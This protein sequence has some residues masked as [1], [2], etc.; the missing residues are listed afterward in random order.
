MEGDTGEKKLETNTYRTNQKKDIH[1]CG[2]S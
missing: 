2:I 1:I